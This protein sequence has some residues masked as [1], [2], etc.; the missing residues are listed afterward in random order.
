MLNSL[1]Q[2]KTIN[3]E[4]KKHLYKSIAQSIKS[5]NI[6]TMNKNT[7]SDV[8]LQRIRNMEIQWDDGKRNG[9]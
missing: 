4:T 6:S 3:K 5:L 9:K 7:F 8:A 1:L 2:E